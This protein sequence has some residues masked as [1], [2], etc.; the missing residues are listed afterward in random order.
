[1]NKKHL[2]QMIL[3]CGLMI[4]C[5]FAATAQTSSL[6]WLK[7]VDDNGGHDSLVFGNNTN[8][9]FFVDS[10]IGE[11][12]SPPDAPGFF[13]KFTCPRSPA[14]GNWGLGIIHKDLR[15]CP[16]PLTTTVVRKDSFYVYFKNDDVPATNANVTLTWPSADWITARCDSM[17]LQDPTG[18][19]IPG[20]NVNMATTNSIVLTDP[21]DQGGSNPSAPVIKLRIY[22]YD[23]VPPLR[24][25]VHKES[26]LT[27]SSYALHQNYPNPF[28][29]TTTMKFDILKTGMTNISV[30]N[31]LGQKVA[32]LVSGQ[33]TPGTY[34][35]QW[36]GKNDFNETVTSGIYFVR[37]N[38]STEGQ[39]SFSDVRKVV[40]MK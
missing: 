22:K 32:T 36:N 31:V 8:G 27:P 5:V 26:P 6:F 15:D 37:M 34:S 2:R 28:N 40:M 10:L 20:K 9:T 13:A 23:I 21:Y 18:I 29:P 4:L 33:L 39:S 7:I 35:V 19:L 12:S 38:V 30:Y 3:L 25:G 17:I 11:Y 14:Q 1:M 24:E 16:S